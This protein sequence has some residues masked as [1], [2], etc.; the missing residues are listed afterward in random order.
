MAKTVDFS[1]YLFIYIFIQLFYILS[2]HIFFRKICFTDL[3]RFVSD[4]FFVTTI[5]VK[6]N[7]IMILYSSI[8]LSFSTYF[9]SHNL[10]I[11]FFVRLVYACSF[12]FLLNVLSIVICFLFSIFVK[13]FLHPLKYKSSYH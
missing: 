13:F 9:L 8:I 2:F 4:L 7:L 10:E 12:E 5:R 3:L 6:K 1:F 11:R